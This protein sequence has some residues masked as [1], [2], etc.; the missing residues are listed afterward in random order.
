M[1][2]RDTR[3]VE[4]AIR[5]RWDIPPEAFT[6]VPREMHEVIT[7]D[8]ASP[9][10]KIAATRALALMHGQNQADEHK[11]QADEVLHHIEGKVGIR[12]LIDKNFYGNADRLAAGTVDASVATPATRRSE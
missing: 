9:R 7:D 10:N 8:D 12:V 4:S 5:G 2:T 11:R 6:D 1:T 3:L